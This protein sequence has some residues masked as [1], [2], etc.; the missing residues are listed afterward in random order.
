LLEQELT[1]EKLWGLAHF[2]GRIFVSSMRLLYELVD[3]QLTAVAAPDDGV[4]PSSTY[5]LDVAGGVLWSAGTKEL[6]EFDGK[7]WT[8]LLNFF[9]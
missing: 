9:D 7:R 8:L 1:R 3:D 5:R 4:F 2:G 6:Y